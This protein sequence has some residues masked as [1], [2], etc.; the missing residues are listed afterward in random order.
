LQETDLIVCGEKF[1]RGWL[2]DEEID[3]L[4]AQEKGKKYK[5]KDEEDFGLGDVHGAFF[6][7]IGTGM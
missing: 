7:L 4:A 3:Q 1:V 5:M 6:I 2:D